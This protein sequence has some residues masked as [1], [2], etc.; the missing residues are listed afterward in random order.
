MDLSSLPDAYSQFNHIIG[1]MKVMLCGLMKLVRKIEM[2]LFNDATLNR[3]HTLAASEQSK[4]EMKSKARRRLFEDKGIKPKKSVW[5]P[6]MVIEAEANC[7]SCGAKGHWK[8]NCSFYHEGATSSIG[9][10]DVSSK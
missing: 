5:Q 4:V 8:I 7:F 3:S 9:I 10:S 6:P 2:Q 1:C